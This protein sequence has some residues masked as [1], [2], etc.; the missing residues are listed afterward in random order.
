M[1][2]NILPGITRKLILEICKNH[3]IDFQEC[4]YN[5]TDLYNADEVFLYGT[6]TE[7][8]PVIAIDNKII[9]DK[10]SGAITKKLYKKLHEKMRGKT[11]L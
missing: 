11:S 7:V 1:T 5:L 4:F 2:N 6:T 9:G 8:L 10:K 3:K